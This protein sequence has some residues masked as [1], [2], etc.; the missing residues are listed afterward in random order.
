M[1]ATDRNG[2]PNFDPVEGASEL[3]NRLRR[4]F[5]E[6]H[7]FREQLEQ[8]RTDLD[9]VTNELLQFQHDYCTDEARENEYMDCLERILGYSVRIDPKELEEARNNPRTIDD[10]ICEIENA[11]KT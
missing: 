1:S 4:F 5:A 6:Q 10:I 7:R 9:R 11:E 8:T 2:L 3:E